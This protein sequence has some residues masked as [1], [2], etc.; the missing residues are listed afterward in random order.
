MKELVEYIAKS[1]VDDPSQVHV[2]T[3]DD[4]A[5]STVLELQVAPEDMGRVIGKSGRVA[6]AMRILVR[7]MAT[8]QG[9]RV[10]L[11]IV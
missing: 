4:S 11:D 1:L 3:V 5:S 2:T 9:K 10:T 8:K 7:V 6:N